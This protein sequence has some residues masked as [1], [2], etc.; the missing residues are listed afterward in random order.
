MTLKQMIAHLEY[1][2]AK[3]SIL[4]RRHKAAAAAAAEY[5]YQVHQRMQAEGMEPGDAVT[6]KGTRWGMQ[7]DWYGVVQDP[8]EF[9]A[10]AEEHAPH[11][12][13][14]KPDKSLLNQLARQHKEDGTPLPP[15]V[16]AAPKPW[17][18]RRAS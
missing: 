18:S 3:A 14:P 10:W 1:L 4:Y 9:N 15:G 11:L 2:D 7:Y 8:F 13:K 6:Y 17:V 5:E 16:G 12:I